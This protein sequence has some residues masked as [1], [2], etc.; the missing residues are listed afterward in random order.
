MKNF[1][2]LPRKEDYHETTLIDTSVIGREAY[3][4]KDLLLYHKGQ[5]NMRSIVDLFE[6]TLKVDVIDEE[7][8]PE[9]EKQR[10]EY[11]EKRNAQMRTP[12]QPMGGPENILEQEHAFAQPFPFGPQP[13][14]PIKTLTLKGTAILYFLGVQ[15]VIVDDFKE[16][17]AMYNHYLTK[18]K[19]DM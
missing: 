10:N 3:H 2:E 12:F 13:Q 6:I 19:L 16:F 7:K 9:F 5:V 17:Q 8:F 11:I 15:R 1:I 4:E 18:Q 14:L